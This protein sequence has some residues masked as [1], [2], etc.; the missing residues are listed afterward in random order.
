MSLLM[1]P[2]PLLTCPNSPYVYPIQKFCVFKYMYFS[3]YIR[4]FCPFL[5]HFFFFP[6]VRNFALITSLS[7]YSFMPLS[8]FK[9]LYFCML[10][11]FFVYQTC[12]RYPTLYNTVLV[13]KLRCRSFFTNGILI[14][15]L[16]KGEEM[17]KK[18]KENQSQKLA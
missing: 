10:S 14:C 4:H 3:F 15:K 17:Q 2:Y 11:Y 1:H 9:A 8:S 16:E 12:S 13:S 7:S 6:A 18:K 5:L